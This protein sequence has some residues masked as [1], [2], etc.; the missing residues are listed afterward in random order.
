MVGRSMSDA[1]D[2][3]RASV[4]ALSWQLLSKAK[5]GNAVIG[6]GEI[7]SAIENYAA[8]PDEFACEVSVGVDIG[9]RFGDRDFEEGRFLCFRLSDEGIRFDE[10]YT[11]YSSA[12]GGDHESTPMGSLSWN[13]GA[14]GDLDNWFA[15][16]EQ[17]LKQVECRV[18]VSRDHV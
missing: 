12:V 4:Q 6:L 16:T 14:G 18:S 3:Y 5:N 11:T 1:A 17:L 9:F 8:S 10:L 7:I 15:E 13:G 2:R